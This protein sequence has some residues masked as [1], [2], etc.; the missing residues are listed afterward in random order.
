LNAWY[1][2]IFPQNKRSIETY[3]PI[4]VL[5]KLR[6]NLNIMQRNE[7]AA[8]RRD[9]PQKSRGEAIAFAAASHFL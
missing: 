8:E 6:D 1:K 5:K 3:F 9:D 4:A 7:T 2:G